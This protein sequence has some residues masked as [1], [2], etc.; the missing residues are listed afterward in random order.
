MPEQ[1]QPQPVLHLFVVQRLAA[2][3]FGRQEEDSRCESRIQPKAVL[4]VG[5]RFSVARAELTHN[6]GYLPF[7][8][9]VWQHLAQTDNDTHVFILES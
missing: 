6:A 4:F 8:I 5:L 9:D 1:M 3:T 2:D 7:A